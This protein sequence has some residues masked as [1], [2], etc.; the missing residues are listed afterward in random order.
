MAESLLAAAAVVLATVAL[1]LV[2][3][4][5]GPLPADSMM[6]VQLFGTGGVAVLLLLGAASGESAIVDVA[7]TLA[8]LSAFA[9]IAYVKYF[10]GD[11]SDDTTS[12][13]DA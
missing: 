10:P 7:L 13:R 3:V 9:S 11:V 2:R 12:G 4:L 6:A 5:R 8:L 1:G